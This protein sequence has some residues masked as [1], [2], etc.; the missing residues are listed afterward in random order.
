M[1]CCIKYMIEIWKVYLAIMWGF[2]FCFVFFP[3]FCINIF[4]HDIIIGEVM[5][6]I[7]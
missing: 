6:L 4:Y 2:V 3:S 5:P 1:H 7:R